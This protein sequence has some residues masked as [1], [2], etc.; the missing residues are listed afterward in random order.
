MPFD[1]L[2]AAAVRRQL[3]DVLVGARIDKI[4]QP[5]PY[6]IVLHC[7]MPGD[8]VR[9]LLSADPHHARVHL[10]RIS[11]INPLQAPAFCMLLRKYLDPGKIVA[12]E[13]VGLDRILHI[14]I[15]GYDESGNPARRRL[16]AELTGRNSNLVLV[17]DSS[18]RIIDA[19][20]R[21]SARVNRY[22]AV[23]PGE[24]YVPPPATD[25]LEPRSVSATALAAKAVASDEETLSRFLVR[26]VDGLSPLAAQHVA[27][28]ARLQPTAPLTALDEAAFD[29]VSDVLR[30]I[31]TAAEQ[32]RFEPVVVYEG[33]RPADFWAWPPDHISPERLHFVSDASVAVD[34]YYDHYLTQSTRDE[35]RGHLARTVRTA[36]KRL[37]RKSAALQADLDDAAQADKYRLF[38]ELL[39]ANLHLVKQGREATVPNY[40][41]DGAPVTI[42][43]DPALHPAANAQ[44]YFKRYNKA[45]TAR[46]AVQQ[47]LD[48]VTVDIE[49]L[50]RALMHIETADDVNELRDI[51]AELIEAGILASKKKHG[52]SNRRTQRHGKKNAG[53]ANTPL[54]KPLRA[55]ASDGTTIL[56]GRNNRQNDRL[57]LRT[58]K[59]DDIWLHVKDLPG[60]HVVLQLPSGVAEPSEQ[61]LHEAAQLAAY[62]SS[63]RSSSNIAVDWTR[64]RYVR[65]PK[66][67]RPG[68]VIYD[69]HQTVYVTPDEKAVRSLLA[70]SGELAE[71]APS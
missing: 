63:A 71:S 9:L 10:T 44:K 1:G 68:M 70:G 61:A 41:E 11:L 53:R 12:V 59:P 5:S 55:R 58:A 52:T 64:A 20:R 60:A 66:G 50:D 13:Q 23:L 22:R 65:K 39:M 37:R 56:I 33:E 32:G 3:N 17:D 35:L 54:S 69:H 14:V 7:H 16:I 2:F 24:E 40:H 19:I 28:T 26:T 48:A 4:Y 27:A 15:D 38:G 25:K 46:V 49:Y 47:Q 43:L 18:G 29:A 57:T 8:N 45:K 6:T 30:Q 21:A 67:G 34:T 31:A 36:L 42:P 51:E 62:Y